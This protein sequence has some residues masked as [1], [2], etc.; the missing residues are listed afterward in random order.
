M[1][2]KDL[3]GIDFETYYSKDY[4]L[5]LAKYNT[6]GYIRDEQFQIHGCGFQCYGEKPYWVLGHDEALKEC[7]RVDLRSRPVVGHHMAFDGFILHEHAGIHVGRYCDTLSMARGCMGHHIKHNLDAVSQALGFAGKTDGLVH[8]K[9]KRTEDLT[10]LELKV[11]GAYCKND[12]VMCTSVFWKLL[13]FIP[14]D[15]MEIIDLTLRMFCDPRMIVDVQMCEDEWA[16]EVERKRKAVKQTDTCTDVLMS[17]NK[18]ADLLRELGVEPPMKISPT[19]EKETYAFAKTDYGF[20]ELLV[21]DDE[22]IQ[23]VARARVEVKSTINETRALRLRDAGLN[24]MPLPVLLNYAGAHTYRWSG[25][26]KLNLQ[27]LPRGGNLRRAILAPG[28]H[29]LL[30]ADLS[31]IEARLNVWF[32]GQTDM[33]DAF[34]RGDDVYKLMASKI[35]NKVVANVSEAER[36]IG[37]ICILGLGYGMGWK[38]LKATLAIGF[39][40]PPVNISASEARRIV[41]TYRS[42]NAR[43]VRMWDFLSARLPQMAMDTSFQAPLKSVDFLYRMIELPNGLA[44][45]YPGLTAEDSDWGHMDCTYL[46]RYGRNKIYGGLLLENII[47]ALARCVLAEQMLAIHRHPDGSHWPIATSTHDELV[48]VVP[49]AEITHATKVVE[50]IMT[51]PPEWAPDLPLAVKSGYDVCYSK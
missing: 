43:I 18:F 9:G 12:T 8:T 16:N 34:A 39:A 35:Y 28:G 50:K 30:V 21:H 49:D 3:I 20:R 14:E 45:K 29:Q 27:N 7:E 33:V 48:L 24:G 42:L 41:A 32:C 11:L 23:F 37:K 15:E 4:S 25:G 5:S 17:N 38:K 19:T 51:T 40:G 6:S 31:Q 1:E 2:Y 46:G 26:N 36:F 10:P 22:A 44:L 13:E 47:Q